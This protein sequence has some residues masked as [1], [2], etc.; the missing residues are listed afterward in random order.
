MNVTARDADLPSRYQDQLCIDI[1]ALTRL[2]GELVIGEIAITGGDP[3]LRQGSDVAII[4]Q[5]KNRLVFNGMMKKYVSIILSSQS[6]S[7]L[8]FDRVTGRLS[9]SVRVSVSGRFSGRESSSI[10][11]IVSGNSTVRVT[12]WVSGKV[13]GKVRYR[14]SGSSMVMGSVLVSGKDTFRS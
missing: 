5:V 2:F 14:V 12:R 1:S 3:F 9:G 4:I 11:S 6:P 8:F 10:T 7:S 13:S